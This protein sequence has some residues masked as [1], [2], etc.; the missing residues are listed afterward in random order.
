MDEE[1]FRRFLKRGGRSQRAVKRAL[2]L[3]EEFESYLKQK[4][5][6]KR[7]EDANSD[8]L[9]AFVSWIERKENASAKLH[10][11]GVRYYY[12]YTSNERMST[13]AWQLRHREIKRA[14]FKLSE[15]RGVDPEYAKKL[16][17]VGSRNVK[18]MLDAG[19]TRSGR[20][21]LSE[22]AGVPIDAVLELLKLSD[23]ARVQGLKGIRARLL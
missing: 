16:E 21:E 7:L 1:G 19:R 6:G 9:K 3:V 18:E 12:E 14:P 13:L 11:W 23:L 10:L 15:F 2:L 5:G 20:K 17:A 22:K 8:D 4:G